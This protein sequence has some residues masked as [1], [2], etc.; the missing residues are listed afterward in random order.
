MA[1][2]QVDKLGFDRIEIANVRRCFQANA[3][4]YKKLDSLYA[5]IRSLGEDVKSLQDIIDAWEA[6][7]K[8]LSEKKLGKVLSSK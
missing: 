5:K 2:K 7:V 1:T 6:P 8:A 3:S 4:N